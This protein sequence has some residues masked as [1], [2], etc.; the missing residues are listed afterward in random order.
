[1]LILGRKELSGFAKNISYDIETF[2]PHTQVG[3]LNSLLIID[4]SL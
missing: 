2:N 3:I 4:L 1:M